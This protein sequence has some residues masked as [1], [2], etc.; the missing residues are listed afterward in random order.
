MLQQMQTDKK[1]PNSE[2]KENL[3]APNNIFPLSGPYLY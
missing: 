2:M 1:H 3:Q